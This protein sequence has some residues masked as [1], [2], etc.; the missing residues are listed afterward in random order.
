MK[1]I[2]TSLLLV[3]SLN[4]FASSAPMIINRTGKV[5]TVAYNDG[6][7]P[8]FSTGPISV[9][10]DQMLVIPSTAVNNPSATPAGTKYKKSATS[11]A[12]KV[13]NTVD[14][15]IS[16]FAAG[17]SYVVKAD[18]ANAG[19]YTVITAKI[20]YDE[21]TGVRLSTSPDIALISQASHQG[22]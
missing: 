7:T 8:L 19:K 14:V 15:T 4:I 16:S 11:A 22:F 21:S 20:E 6:T 18:P 17:T 9:N 5:M 12:I 3:T 2:I 1:K 13:D 10:A